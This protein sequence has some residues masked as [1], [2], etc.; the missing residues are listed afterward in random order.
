MKKVQI[1][2]IFSTQIN[3]TE[4][5]YFQYISIDVNQLNSDVIKVF[6]NKY[7][8]F[9][10]PDYQDLLSCKVDFFAHTF[11]ITGIKK[12][13]FKKAGS[14]PVIDCMDKIIFR[15]TSDYGTKIGELPILKTNNW[16]FWNLEDNEINKFRMLK[17]DDY[18]STHIGIVFNPSGILELLK[19]NKY[20]VNYPSLF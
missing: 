13:I 19:G 16:K 2:D 3:E 17:V 15:T 10:N 6:D 14:M 12:G 11:L 18:D 7:K 5:K 4:K 9:E 1:G 20:P 8:I